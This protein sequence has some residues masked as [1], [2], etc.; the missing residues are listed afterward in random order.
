MSPEKMGSTM[1]LSV[2]QKAK[3]FNMVKW[4]KIKAFRFYFLSSNEII[5]II[6]I[7]IIQNCSAP[8]VSG[9]SMLSSPL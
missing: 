7:I 1:K 9:A 8:V 6:I 2:E 3:V 5:S 4:V